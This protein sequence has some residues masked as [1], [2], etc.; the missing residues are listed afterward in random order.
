MK[1]LFSMNSTKTT[2]DVSVDIITWIKTELDKTTYSDIRFFS[3]LIEYLR[4]EEMKRRKK[5]A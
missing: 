4:I 2:L 1:A 3:G 5:G